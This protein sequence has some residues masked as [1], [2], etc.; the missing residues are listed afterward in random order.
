[1]N[2]KEIKINIESLLKEKLQ[3]FQ[4]IEN[5]RNQTSAEILKL[6][7]KLELI[8]EQIKDIPKEEIKEDSEK[9]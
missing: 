3:E 8:E 4:D 9:K 1:M 2:L 6:Q 5:Q 7:G